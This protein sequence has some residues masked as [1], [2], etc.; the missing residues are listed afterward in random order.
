VAK[1]KKLVFN[2]TGPFLCL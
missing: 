1:R 2:G